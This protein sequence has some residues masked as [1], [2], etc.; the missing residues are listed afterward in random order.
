MNDSE[1]VEL[2]EL[3][4]A[5]VDGQLT[6]PQ[7]ARLQE[8]LRES[9]EARRFYVRSMELSASLY[10]YAGEM[11]CEPAE[12]QNIIRPTFWRRYAAPLAAAAAVVAVGFWIGRTVPEGINANDDDPE[13]IARISASKDTRWAGQGTFQNG[14]ELH[15]G[16]RLELAAGFAEI[17]FDS[18]AQIVVE[19]PASV[20]L[21]SAWQATLRRGT[22]KANIPQEAI[23]FRVSN[24]SVDVVDLG[25][26]FS[27][28][29]D[30]DGSAEVFVLAGQVEVEPRTQNTAAASKILM[31]E[32]QSRRFAL[33]GVSDVRD[34]DQ[35][36]LKLAKRVT[37]DL[38]K[39]AAAYAH[40]SFD[41][42]DGDIF[43]GEPLGQS[44]KSGSLD[45]GIRN[46][47]VNAGKFGD[48]L[49]LSGESGGQIEIANFGMRSVKTAAF[50][51]RLPEDSSPVD[52]GTFARLGAV[53]LGWNRNPSDGS[54]GAL[55]IANA[56]GHAVASTSLRD[57]RWHHVA[58]VITNAPPSS[59]KPSG[60][61]Q[62]RLYVDGRLEAWTGRHPQRKGA[63]TP[64]IDADFLQIGGAVGEKGFRGEIDELYVADRPLTPMEIRSL[65]R[66]NR[67][68]VPDAFA[69]N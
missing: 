41:S 62:A 25:T 33:S 16:Q 30:E 68:Y 7:N 1:R 69:A 40:W 56:K 12:P 17:T 54:Q 66:N 47:S 28:T 2:N 44:R 50:W 67:P 20:D 43:R 59:A 35:K 5:L 52:G 36:F 19:G 38:P 53:E 4:S 9:A 32:K 11:Q 57:G 49:T 22:L 13:L 63:P 8:L 14:D 64:L 27:I 45:F 39:R 42:M 6:P 55:R 51:V 46:G 48:A 26:E 58:A 21:D 15:R 60:K 24:P 23:G 29:A 18:G 65:M 34:S 31:K 3:C 37:F 61:W 10:S